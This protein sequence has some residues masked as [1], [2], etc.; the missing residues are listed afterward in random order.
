MTSSLLADPA[1]RA[2]V[3]RALKEVDDDFTGGRKEKRV[4]PP[5]DKEYFVRS[6]SQL[7]KAAEQNASTLAK[8]TE[9]RNECERKA[10]TLTQEINARFS[11]APPHPNQQHR[12]AIEAVS[13]I[14]RGE[15]VCVD[16]GRS[17]VRGY[18]SHWD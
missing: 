15:E 5:I 13:D 7:S 12:F 10:A 16:Y 8:I 11:S 3:A 4:M 18:P 2:A 6:I 14:A 9:E 1:R 17:Y